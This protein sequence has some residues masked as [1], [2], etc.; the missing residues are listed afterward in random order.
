MTR[1]ASGKSSMASMSVAAVIPARGGS[2]RLARK[3][4]FLLKG[5]PLLSYVI[6]ACRR[7]VYVQRIYVS[8]ED[9]E[10]SRRCGA[11]PGSAARSAA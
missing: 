10:N 6:E 8:S 1:E 9:P 3:N 2:K 4:L 5:K 11:I 7:S